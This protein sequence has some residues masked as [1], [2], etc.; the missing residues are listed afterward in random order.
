MKVKVMG[1]GIVV[2]IDR[3]KVIGIGIGIDKGIDMGIDR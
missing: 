1:I 3:F 2:I